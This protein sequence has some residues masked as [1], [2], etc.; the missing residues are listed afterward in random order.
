MSRKTILKE[1]GV[2]LIASLM[3]FSSGIVLANTGNSN[4][5][6]NTNQIILKN[7]NN[8]PSYVDPNGSMG[9]AKINGGI[10]ISV[11]LKNTGTINLTNIT[12]T[13]N[14]TGKYMLYYDLNGLKRGQIQKRIRLVGTPV[15][16]GAEATLVPGGFFFGLSKLS[17]RVNATCDEGAT[18]SGNATAML[19]LFYVTGIK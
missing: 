2:L 17:V 14:V 15:L 9:V 8:S 7:P 3:V 16:P 5:C 6:I 19:L 11:T 1:A 18:C 4:V 12:L 10:G 13:L